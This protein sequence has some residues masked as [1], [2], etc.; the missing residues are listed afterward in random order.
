MFGTPLCWC[1]CGQHVSAP[2][3]RYVHG[4]NKGHQRNRTD[5]HGHLQCV[6]CSLFKSPSE[7]HKSST[8]SDGL[9]GVCKAC[10][11]PEGRHNHL[12]KLYGLTLDEYDALWKAQGNGC[13]VC[14]QDKQ[15]RQFPVDHNH[16]TDA[17]RG[18][19]CDQCNLALGLLK[20]DVSVLKSMISYLEQHTKTKAA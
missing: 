11:R 6:R 9:R 4:H 5:A 10:R 16:A 13:A 19:L 1:G 8:R 20:D 17:V 15:V 3:K 12:V 2:S 7:F 14:K 18:I